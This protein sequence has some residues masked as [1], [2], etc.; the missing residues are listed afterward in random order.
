MAYVRNYPSFPNISW[1]IWMGISAFPEIK[2]VSNVARGWTGVSICH[3]ISSSEWENMVAMPCREAIEPRVCQAAWIRFVPF[4][5]AGTK[6]QKGTSAEGGAGGG[7]RGGTSGKR[8]KSR[9][10]VGNNGSVWNQETKRERD[11]RGREAQIWLRI[12]HQRR[13][14]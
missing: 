11:E 12:S 8:E 9:S 3:L 13:R 7:S 6:E 2:L 5:G 10:G 1:P 14:D 4:L